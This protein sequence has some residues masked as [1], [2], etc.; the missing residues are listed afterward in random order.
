[1]SWNGEKL[2][3]YNQDSVSRLELR[4]MEALVFVIQLERTKE[5]SRNGDHPSYVRMQRWHW[6]PE[7]LQQRPGLLP[8]AAAQNESQY[9]TSYSHP[10]LLLDPKTSRLL[11][12]LG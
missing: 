2:Q 7:Q 8:L 1:M 5:A 11:V 3:G 9:M 4:G 12:F 10:V 6:L